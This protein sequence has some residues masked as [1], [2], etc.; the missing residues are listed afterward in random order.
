MSFWKKNK[1]YLEK[2]NFIRWPQ[3]STDKSANIMCHRIELLS[4]FIKPISYI[5]MAIWFTPCPTDQRYWFF[6]PER[7]E[8][9]FT[10]RLFSSLSARKRSEGWWKY[11]QGVALHPLEWRKAF[12]SFHPT[13]LVSLMY[14][15]K[16]F[17]WDWYRKMSGRIFSCWVRL[18]PWKSIFSVSRARDWSWRCWHEIVLFTQIDSQ[19]MQIAIHV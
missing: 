5:F 2:Y 14:S 4:D 11:F 12:R 15:E 16:E 8:M 1:K 3:F 6:R 13:H 19:T 17:P 9:I 18:E 7:A 10:K